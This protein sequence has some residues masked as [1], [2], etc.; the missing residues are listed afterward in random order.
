MARPTW[1]GQISFGLVTVP[2]QMYTAVR[3]QDLT[4]RQINA[5]THARVRH[6]RVDADT[7]EEVPTHDIQKGYEIAKDSYV[8]VDPAELDRLAPKASGTIDIR[9]FVP[10]QQIDPIYYDKP[11]YLVPDGDLA[12]RPYEL[13]SRAMEGRAQSAIATFVMRTKEYLAAIRASDGRLVLST[14]HYADEVVDATSLGFT[15]TPADVDDRDLDM[16]EQL[17]EKFL[18]DFEPTSYRD[19]HRE[20]VRE[21]L[22]SKMAGEQVHIPADDRA[23]AEV[24]DLRAALE[25]SLQRGAQ[26][27]GTANYDA[28][29]K[30]E[31]YDIAKERDLPGRSD[32]KKAELIEALLASDTSAAA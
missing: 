29:T 17:I 21:F 14:M 3:S 7:G 22:E 4:F 30:D 26:S 24:I 16:A 13:L 5:S 1:K 28:M 20:R 27:A 10:T 15:K 31:L 6:K 23:D 8:V 25:R 2:V 11:Y 9:D 32:M 18:T 12:A 19:Q